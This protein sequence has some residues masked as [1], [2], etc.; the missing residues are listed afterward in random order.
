M[1]LLLSLQLAAFLGLLLASA[2]FSGSETALFGLSRV[3]RKAMERRADP[4]SRRV[5]TLLAEPR[6]LLVTILL[7]NTLV[8]TALSSLGTRVATGFVPGDQAIGVAIAAVTVVLVLCGEVMPKILAVRYSEVFSL[9]VAPAMTSLQMVLL[10]VVSRIQ[11]FTDAC[12]RSMPAG[13]ATLTTRELSTLLRIG[14]EGGAIRGEEAEL[15]EGILA[16]RETE[17]CDVMTPRVEVEGLRFDPPPPD[18]TAEVKRLGRR[19]VPLYG[20]D[21]DDLVGLFRARSF[22]L[23][24]PSAEPSDFVIQPYMV[25]ETKKL[26]DLLEDFRTTGISTAVVLDEHGGFSGLVTLEDILEE[27]FGEVFDRGEPEEIEVRPRDDGYRILGKTPL[28]GV[29]SALGIL[30]DE[31]EGEEVSTLAGFVMARLGR[32][33]RRGDAVEHGGW[34]FRVAHVLRRRVV[35]VDAIRV[36]AVPAGEGQAAP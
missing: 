22:L 29:E 16:L 24:G 27:V 33:P 36:T 8:N 6:T 20:K 35:S 19:M 31:D 14:E 4:A 3:K 17:V 26:A 34:S 15:V 28:P 2:F 5:L 11:A 7:G 21:L 30:F 32:V 12:L 13:D 23:A 18:M 25:P 1:T 9:R 10:P